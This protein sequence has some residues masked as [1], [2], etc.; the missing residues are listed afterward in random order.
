M[1]ILM[2]PAELGLAYPKNIKKSEEN[3]CFQKHYTYHGFTM[4]P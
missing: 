2:V 4:K 1:D 3:W